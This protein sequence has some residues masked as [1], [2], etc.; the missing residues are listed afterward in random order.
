MVSHQI[1]NITA[2]RYNKSPQLSKN[3]CLL[4][5][6]FI[7][8]IL[9]YNINTVKMYKCVICEK[10]FDLQ[11]AYAGH[12]KIHKKSK[13]CILYEENPKVCKECGGDISYGA[14]RH[15]HLVKFCSGSCRAKSCNKTRKLSQKGNIRDK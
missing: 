8:N 3:I 1:F 13:T 9:P 6:F 15:N 7:L 4:S 2:E 12:L 5:K 14:Y 10:I 11:R